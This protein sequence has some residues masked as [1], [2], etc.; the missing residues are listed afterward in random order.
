MYFLGDCMT[1][2]L[3]WPLRILWCGWGQRM[4]I[5]QLNLSILLWLV[6]ELSL[7]LMI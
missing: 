4:I 1:T 3:G 2:P 5:S 7:S 6:G